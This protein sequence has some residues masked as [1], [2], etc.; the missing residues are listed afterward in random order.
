MPIEIISE[1]SAKNNGQ[2]ALL[3]DGALRGSFRVCSNLS[4]R[5]AIPT[6]KRKAGMRVVVNSTDTVYKLANDLITW[7]VDNTATINLQNAYNNGHSI[8]VMNGN[9]V[10]IQSSNTTA[11]SLFEIQ[12]YLSNLIFGVD[13]NSRINFGKQLCGKEYTSSVTSVVA[14]NSLNVY[15]DKIDKLEYR[16]VQYF[17]TV[18]NSDNSGF[19]TGQIFIIH[20]GLGAVIESTTGTTIGIPCG[21]SF[22]VDMVAYDINLLAT[23]DNSGIFSRVVNLFKIALI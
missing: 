17:Y 8:T 22:G 4:E 15:L 14:T 11:T 18:S 9:P 21:I 16:A 7:T 3:D 5:N 6:D 2:F 23:T 13:N 19:E 1:L 10:I 12:D 20:N